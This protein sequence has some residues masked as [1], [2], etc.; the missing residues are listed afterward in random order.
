MAARKKYIELVNA[1]KV[2]MRMRGAAA[3]DLHNT[4]QRERDTIVRLKKSVMT[5]NKTKFRAM[6]VARY[7]EVFHSTPEKDGVKVVEQMH[8]GKKQK[9]CLVRKRAKG[10]WDVEIDEAEGIEQDTVLDDG[11]AVASRRQQQSIFQGGSNR[12][13]AP[14]MSSTMTA[15]E[16]LAKIQEDAQAEAPQE[17]EGEDDE[18]MDAGSHSSVAEDEEDPHAG[19][20][21]SPSKQARKKQR[22][23]KHDSQAEAGQPPRASRGGGDRAPEAARANAGGASRRHPGPQTSNK[24]KQPNGSEKTEAGAAEGD[25]DAGGKGGKPKTMENLCPEELEKYLAEV[26]KGTLDAEFSDVFQKVCDPTGPLQ[27]VDTSASAFK[28]VITKDA[29][30]P[31]T[32]LCVPY[33]ITPRILSPGG[34]GRGPSGPGPALLDPRSLKTWGRAS[35][36][37]IAP[38]PRARRLPLPPRAQD[39]GESIAGLRKLHAKV[40]AMEWKIKKRKPFPQNAVD[41]MHS[42]RE[43]V[44][45][46]WKCLAFLNGKEEEFEVVKFE[47][48]VNRLDNIEGFGVPNSFKAWL[49]HFNA[50]DCFAFNRAEEL[51]KLVAGDAGFGGDPAVDLAKFT[52]LPL[53]VDALRVPSSS[54]PAFPPSVSSPSSSQPSPHPPSHGAERGGGVGPSQ[55]APGG[56]PCPSGPS[57]PRKRPLISMRSL[58]SGLKVITLEQCIAASLRGVSNVQF[59]AGGKDLLVKFV[60]T[61]PPLLSLEFKQPTLLGKEFFNAIRMLV[62]ALDPSEDRSSKEQRDAWNTAVTGKDDD[63]A[64]T[65]PLGFFLCSDLPSLLEDTVEALISEKAEKE[66]SNPSWATLSE[67]LSSMTVDPKAFQD[68]KM[69]QLNSE[70]PKLARAL[71]DAKD[72]AR[73]KVAKKVGQMLSLCGTAQDAIRD[74]YASF[75]TT[76]VGGYAKATDEGVATVASEIDVA[77]AILNCDFITRAAKFGRAFAGLLDTKDGDALKGAL[78]EESILHITALKEF[79]SAMDT[80]QSCLDTVVQVGGL[81][82]KRAEEPH[83]TDIMHKVSSLKALASNADALGGLHDHVTSAMQPWFTRFSFGSAAQARYAKVKDAVTIS[84]KEFLEH[85]DTEQWD[86]GLDEKVAPLCKQ[87]CSQIYQAKQMAGCSDNPKKELSSAESIGDLARC[88]ADVTTRSKLMEMAQSLKPGSQLSSKFITDVIALARSGTWLSSLEKV[89]IK[90]YPEGPEKAKDMDW[91]VLLAPGLTE[92]HREAVFKYVCN[93]HVAVRPSAAS[94]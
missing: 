93:H 70:V 19:M 5:H 31:K 75:F 4:L 91:L 61:T 40:I 37:S 48:H 53:S 30:G 92:S 55:R 6:T 45:A 57:V 17:E 15:D 47:E 80:W 59:E 21:G 63:N 84:T 41:A 33:S 18:A 64:S 78:G 72:D 38:A 69:N 56:C 62:S 46:L 51:C 83:L 58:A 79:S 50:K 11:S 16:L 12:L 39:L 86:Q 22:Q 20:F 87:L 85:F 82:P 65:R 1:G 26:G 23:G 25:A 8:E 43:D 10:E 94:P 77:A 9:V 28:T 13:M 81:F 60:E 73:T 74:Q 76:I 7:E 54:S 27:S 29:V 24:R 71:L 49:F 89:Y 3:R 68:D 2:Q 52:E 66:L 32:E 67:L 88:H 36:P 35:C 42:M 90:F 34:F 14:A 44:G